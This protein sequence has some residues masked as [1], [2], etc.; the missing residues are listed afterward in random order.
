M[1]SHLVAE[2]AGAALSDPTKYTY[3]Q[4]ERAYESWCVETGLEAWPSSERTLARYLATRESESIQRYQGLVSAIIH[5]HSRRGLPSPVPEGG[6]VRKMLA[7]L[8]RTNAA[9]LKVDASEDPI[10]FAD[11]MAMI[12]MFKDSTD[13]RVRKKVAYLAL[14]VFLGLRHDNLR[15]L[16][17]D[18]LTIE[19]D[20]LTV[21]LRRSK[22]D[23]TA[24]GQ[25]RWLAHLEDCPDTCPACAVIRHI[26]TLPPETPLFPARGK[27]RT[28]PGGIHVFTGT[29]WLNELCTTSG[30]LLGKEIR[31]RSMRSGFITSLLEA[32][33]P[34]HDVAA[35]V[36]HQKIETTKRY[37]RR[38]EAEKA[39]H[40]DV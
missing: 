7:G 18:D 32:G 34:I 15:R 27:T 31:T 19:S 6:L 23:Q 13:P 38:S 2:L 24:I 10:R 30:L 11:A 14:G 40:L 29:N 21:Q 8:A 1:S 9:K 12:A 26:E 35:A 37:D 20:G 22:S 28:S 33:I 5:G 4:A 25:S 16:R 36:G 3:S 39:Y 17:T